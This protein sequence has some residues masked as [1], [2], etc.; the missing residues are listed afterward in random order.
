MRQKSAIRDSLRLRR[1][2]CSAK[3]PRLLACLFLLG[4]CGCVT[5][6]LSEYQRQ[7][8]G[9]AQAR[10]NISGQASRV[11]GGKELS[12]AVEVL[13]LVQ[14]E[15]DEA[16]V[17][18]VA[19]VNNP[20]LALQY[21][22]LGIARSALLRA[23]RPPN[24]TAEASA[25]F[26]ENH[27]DAVDIKALQDIVELALLPRRKHAAERELDAAKDRLTAKIMGTALEARSVFAE[28]Q[29]A[30]ALAD[31][32]RQAADCR[33]A[34]ADVARR[35]TEAGNMTVLERSVFDQ[36][37]QAARLDLAAWQVQV[38]T[39]RE[40]VNR[41]MGLHEDTSWTAKPADAMADV[42][43]TPKT[44]VDLAALNASLELS[45]Q[46]H[47]LEALAQQRGIINTK[48]YL[49]EL[50]VGV[51]SERASDGSW[52][53]GPA[54]VLTLPL[55]EQ[56]QGQR[57]AVDFQIQAGWNRYAAT[58]VAIA[59]AARAAADRLD[60]AGQSLKMQ[61]E[62]VLPL[63]DKALK[64]TLLQYNGMLVGVFDL[65]RAKERQIEAAVRLA[66]T[67]Q[68]CRLARLALQ[69]AL[70]GGSPMAG[71]TPALPAQGQGDGGKDGH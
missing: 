61:R 5:P 4:I 55:F 51:D 39:K 46:R 48:A 28:Y 31:T 20:G 36:G 66:E 64:E 3:V 71:T 62:E 27:T 12:T 65:L 17:T 23:A 34:A 63:S 33:E 6:P 60:A 67:A 56:G 11:R 53:V 21:A 29:T 42:S 24:P 1:A 37:Y 54:L 2:H 41:V 18:Q 58:A 70:A 47:E 38:R 35:M 45:A 10:A 16:A 19:L 50:R 49:P 30:L 44:G 25:R 43:G 59:S 26:G 14:G 9:D 40:A 15:L 13:P 57:A 7:A 22:D 8:A 68:E 69:H 52:A 32:K